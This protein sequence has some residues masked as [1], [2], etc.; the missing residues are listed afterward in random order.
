MTEVYL[1]RHAHVDYG[2]GIAI[3][4]QNPLTDLGQQMAERLN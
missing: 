2:E 4:A 3:T 1:F